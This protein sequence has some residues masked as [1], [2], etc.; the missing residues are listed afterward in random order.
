MADTRSQRV[1]FE[2]LEVFLEFARTE[3]FGRTAAEL[4][5]SVATVQRSVRALERKLGV[6]LVEQAGRQ[7]RLL[8]SGHVLAREAHG[9]LRARS[10]AIDATLV[11]AGGPR[12]LLRVAHTYS[13][14]LRFVPVALS[15]LLSEQQGLRFRCWQGSA[16]SVLSSLL[17]GEADIA[18]TSLAPT[19]PRMVVQPLFTESL[20]LVVPTED[21]LVGRPSVDLAEVR[22][23]PFVTMEPGSSSRTHLVNACA[24]A[25]F[26][27]RIAVEVND[28]FLVESMVGAG[29]GVSVVPE[30]MSDHHHPRVARLPIGGTNPPTRTIFVAYPAGAASHDSTHALARIARGMG[31]ARS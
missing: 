19:E 8:P 7:V 14:G 10:D 16:T 18:F 17:R 4:N 12:R 31:R 21:P 20:M 27:P 28:L 11:E 22:D 5:V 9:V 13:L 23:R 1:S 6:A 26:V 30:G 25:G 24:R 2:D 15:T 3:H 29:L